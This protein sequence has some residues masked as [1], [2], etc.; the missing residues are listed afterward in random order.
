MSEGIEHHETQIMVA[1]VVFH[2][3]L[4]VESFLCNAKDFFVIRVLID[5]E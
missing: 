2:G 5:V 3:F 4:Q 1:G